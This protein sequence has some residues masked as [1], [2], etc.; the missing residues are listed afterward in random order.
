[1]STGLNKHLRQLILLLTASLLVGW[2]LGHPIL[3]LALALAVYAGGM[4]HQLIR[5]HRWLERSNQEAEP[6][7]AP[8]LWGEVLDDIYRLQKRHLRAR[9]R[10]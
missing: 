1:M 3:M 7:E 10:L 6:P 4:L 9:D 2:L 8:G 5:L